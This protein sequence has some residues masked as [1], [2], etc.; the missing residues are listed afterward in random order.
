MNN[1][2]NIEEYMDNLLSRKSIFKNK[3]ALNPDFIPDYL[4][5]RDKEI[6]E[7]VEI[8][9]PFVLGNKGSN[10]LLYGKT[11]TGKTACVRFILKALSNKAKSHGF[12]FSFSFSNCRMDGSEYRVLVSLGSQLGLKLPFT[13]LATAEVLQRIV[14]FLQ[15]AEVRCIFVL[16]EVDCLIK[17]S[18]DDLLYE[19]TRI[20]ENLKVPLGIITISNDISFK[21]HLDPRV[22]SSLSEEELIF[23]PYTSSQLTDI[24]QSRSSLAFNE[25]VLDKGVIPLCAALAAS[26]H[27]D[28]RRA[29]SLLR[30]AG[31]V[32]ERKGLH[33]VDE[34]CVRTAIKRIE[35]DQSIELIR[36]LPLQS[37]IILLA[38]LASSKDGTKATSGE[39]FSSYKNITS[40]MGVEAL[41]Y[42]RFSMLINE[43]EI[44]GLIE[45]K[46]ISQGR[47]GRTR[48]I[49][50]ASP[51]DLVTRGLSED[52]L[53]HDIMDKLSLLN[54]PL[55]SNL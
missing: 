16:D 43:L 11:G 17:S 48:F 33:I 40:F 3:S 9:T 55:E 34:E 52:L 23:K 39:I 25:G 32:A 38:I 21:E 47:Y 30:V 29:L 10:V 35:E 2:K 7:L 50:V 8:I 37:K 19:L 54:L 45:G 41:T 15:K 26:E 51:Q 5:H 22:L 44:S 46:V 49:R 13:G 27:G 42:R 18:G 12:N 53:L 1:E 4:P 24:L 28:A 14:S 36:T 6:R 31:E 20:N